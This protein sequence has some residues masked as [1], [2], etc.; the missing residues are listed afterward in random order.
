MACARLSVAGLETINWQSDESEERTR[1]SC[2]LVGALC[3]QIYSA[4]AKL[5][6]ATL[7]VHARLPK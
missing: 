7:F 6:K 4:H 1:V 2:G 3:S 5:P